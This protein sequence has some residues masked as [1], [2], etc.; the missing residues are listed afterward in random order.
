MKY[1][2][3]IT[4][5]ALMS[6][7]LLLSA[8]MAQPSKKATNLKVLPKDI[9]HE[10]LDKVM[11]GFKAALGV[12][13]NYCHAAKKDDPKKLDFASDDKPEKEIARN[14]MRMTAKINKKYFHTKDTQDGKALIAV[15]CI[16]CHNGKEHPQAN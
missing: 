8:F 3:T 9:S 11:D 7:V 1:K 6:I 4:F 5:S 14:M 10:E 16:T 13:C 12:K 2:K 15:S